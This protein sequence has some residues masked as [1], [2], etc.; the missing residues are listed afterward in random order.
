MDRD[1]LRACF[2]SPSDHYR[3]YARRGQRLSE[4]TTLCGKQANPF[5]SRHETATCPEC[6]EIARQ[7]DG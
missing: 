4:A 3:H 2:A 1:Q 5:T 7:N 6:K